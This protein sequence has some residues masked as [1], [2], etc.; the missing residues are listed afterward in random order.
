MS[1]KPLNRQGSGVASSDHPSVAGSHRIG[2][3]TYFV[4]PPEAPESRF[5]DYRGE[6]PS[7]HVE[8][9]FDDDGEDGLTFDLNPVESD[10]DSPTFSDLSELAPS[11]VELPVINISELDGPPVPEARDQIQTEPKSSTSPWENN[12]SD[13]SEIDPQFSSMMRE[14]SDELDLS[15]TDEHLAT[16]VKDSL[17]LESN[18]QANAHH[19]QRDD[20]GDT[21]D[22]HTIITPTI[23]IVQSESASQE[24]LDVENLHASALLEGSLVVPAHS[25]QLGLAKIDQGQESD[26]DDD[27]SI[28]N[29]WQTHVL[30][31]YAI[32]MTFLAFYL[33]WTRIPADSAS[34]PSSPTEIEK[35][36]NKENL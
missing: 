13:S 17:A 33:W 16:E 26:Y 9:I 36:L 24:N 20:E 30:I 35:V 23:S 19:N 5:F 28:L 32:F 29:R 21:G 7:N 25:P 11:T 10:P 3:N 6:I 1:D 34:T 27:G 2:G 14:S 8:P 22:F 15:S 31:N 18:S 4:P 12:S